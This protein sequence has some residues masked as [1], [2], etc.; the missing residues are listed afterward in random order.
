M[1]RRAVHR[2]LVEADIRPLFANHDL[3]GKSNRQVR[4]AKD[5]EGRFGVFSSPPPEHNGHMEANST[6]T[7]LK[8]AADTI[9]GFVRLQRAMYG[10]KQDI[11]AAQAA[12][13]LS[14]IQ[15]IER[16]QPVSDEKLER[17][18]VALRQEPGAFTSPRMPLS[19]Q[20]ATRLLSDSLKWME[21]RVPVSVAPLRKAAQLRALTETDL[22][23]FESDLGE[24]AADDLAELREW[25][26]LTGFIRAEVNGL[27]G[28]KAEP[29][30]RLRELYGHVLSAVT[31]IERAH[32]AV[33]LS[34]AYKAP[35]NLPPFATASAGVLT[36]RSR[37]QNPAAA[38]IR[39]LLAPDTIDERS[40]IKAFMEE[41]L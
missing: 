37:A 22:V 25:I 1:G 30:T 27:L 29:S 41:E 2:P 12:V 38:R 9:A 15:R 21:G 11:L 17:V 18:A 31:R 39:R 40:A 34:G 20:E 10:W 36:V 14:T 16:G 8:P 23:I 24:D 3:C 32:R 6:N 33:C 13:S 4:P 28:M 19:D 35:S 26:D 5:A 7:C